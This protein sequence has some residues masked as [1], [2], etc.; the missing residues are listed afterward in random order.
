MRKPLIGLTAGEIENTQKP[1]APYTHGQSF[2]YVEAIVHAGGV[3]VILPITDD[4]EVWRE[5]Y[6]RCDGIV[7]AGGNDVDPARYGQVM[8]AKTHDVSTFRDA[9]EFALL[10]LALAGTKPVL[11]I[12]RG[13]QLLN[14]GLGGT[15]FQDVPE[16]VVGAQNHEASNTEKDVA[17]M[18]HHL[19]LKPDSKLARLVGKGSLPTNTHHHQAVDRVAPSL[20]AVAWAEDGVVEGLELQGERFI[21]GVQSHPES[22]EAHAEPRWALLF[23][24]FVKEAAKNCN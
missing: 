10:Q 2:T 12:C 24:A 4:E 17:R 18:A 15:L 14:V 5:L 7:L 6:E 3:P 13:M 11:A 20:Q 22:L 23:K 19:T 1:W 8:H 21:I 9:Q 16:Q